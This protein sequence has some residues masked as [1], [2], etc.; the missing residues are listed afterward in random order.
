M[1]ENEEYNNYIFPMEFISLEK[2]N[3]DIQDSVLLTCIQH[4][5]SLSWP[6]C[7]KQPPAIDIGTS[8][9]NFVRNLINKNKLDSIS[10]NTET[11]IKNCQ[12]L[13]RRAGINSEDKPTSSLSAPPPPSDIDYNRFIELLQTMLSKTGPPQPLLPSTK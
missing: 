7:P 3:T 1:P 2:R 12:T 8:I 11:D 6:S 10:G 13:E 4:L 9:E 5:L